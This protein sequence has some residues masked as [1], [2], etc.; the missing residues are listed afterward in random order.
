MEEFRVALRSLTERICRELEGQEIPKETVWTVVDRP[1]TPP[2]V[3]MDVERPALSET[4]LALSIVLLRLPED[5]KVADA[6]ENDADLREG[7]IIDAGGVLRPPERTNLTRTLV[8]NFLWR[9]LSEGRHLEWDE[10]KFN[11]TFE[12]LK[13]EL[14]SKRVVFHTI[15]PLSNLKV[16]IDT[17]D[18]DKELR[19]RPAS[20]EEL[21][22]WL[23]DR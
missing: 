18:F 3:A 6:A 23:W 15:L 14:A 22:R 12:E 20:L 5:T 13:A 4:R 16:A 19:L 11:E 1:G 21:E 17:L 8:T 7:I 2:Y 9:Y 10:D